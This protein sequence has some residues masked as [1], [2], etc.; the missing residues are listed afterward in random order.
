MK[1]LILEHDN[2]F[3]NIKYYV[4]SKLIKTNYYRKKILN[5]K[6]IY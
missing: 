5:K 1:L 4:Y 2:I 3:F 6:R